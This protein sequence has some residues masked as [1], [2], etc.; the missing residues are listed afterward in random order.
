MSLFRYGFTVQR[1][2]QLSQSPDVEFSEAAAP[3]PYLPPQESTSL[4]SVEFQAVVSA[5]EDEIVPD[6]ESLVNSN[7]S[8][9]LSGFEATQPGLDPFISAVISHAE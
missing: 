3:S 5:I 9:N 1:T 8:A 6:L 2:A 4:G 7:P